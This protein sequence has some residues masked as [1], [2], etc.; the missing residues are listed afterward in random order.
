MTKNLAYLQE[1]TVIAI[2]ATLQ[3]IAENKL[4]DYMYEKFGF[5]NVH[6][7]F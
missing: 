7:E 1:P 2:F 4:K 6:S 5:K 3:N